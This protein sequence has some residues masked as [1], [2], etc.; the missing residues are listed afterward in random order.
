MT[1]DR[2]Q[3]GGETGMNGLHYEGGQFL[4]NTTLGKLPPKAKH[5]SIGY[6]CAKMDM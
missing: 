4:P 2:A 6:T 5:Q 1:N 3:R